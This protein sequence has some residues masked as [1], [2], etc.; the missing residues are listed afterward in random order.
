MG[1]EPTDDEEALIDDYLERRQ[2]AVTGQYSPARP[3]LDKRELA[4]KREALWTV[5][6]LILLI[7]SVYIFWV[8]PYQLG[9]RPVQVKFEKKK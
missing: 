3:R 9:S 6:L 4:R 1:S 2:K 5:S 8:L 7:G